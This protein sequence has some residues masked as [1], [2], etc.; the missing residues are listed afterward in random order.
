M[1]Q[2]ATHLSFVAILV[3]TAMVVNVRVGA[4]HRSHQARVHQDHSLGLLENTYLSQL[5]NC[6]EKYKSLEQTCC[7]DLLILAQDHI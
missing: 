2:F 5:L 6:L 4:C 7:R 1:V 3:N